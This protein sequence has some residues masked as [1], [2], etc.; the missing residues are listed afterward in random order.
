MKIY[1][2]TGDTGETSLL[3][4]ER[5]RKDHHRI[6]AYGTIDELNSHVGVVRAAWQDGAID[7]E[8]AAI[9][10]DLFDIGA[11]LASASPN[12]KFR[13]VAEPRI[14]VLERTIDR[15][16]SELAPL[17]NFVLPGGSPA[18]A[19]AHVA[20]TVCRRSERMVVALGEPGDDTSRATRYLNRLSD[21]LFVAARYANHTA[22]VEDVPWKAR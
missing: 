1:T 21:F 14:E 8:L 9:Q 11:L 10:S 7:A 3:G 15:M 17:K 12:E 2:K 4:G 22:G 16:E 5:V 19:A 13:G 18:A 20:R 6:E